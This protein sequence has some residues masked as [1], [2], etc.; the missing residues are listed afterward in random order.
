MSAFPV[1]DTSMLT[2]KNVIIMELGL[3]DDGSPSMHRSWLPSPATNVL[4]KAMY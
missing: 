1:E 4:F 2:C 3:N